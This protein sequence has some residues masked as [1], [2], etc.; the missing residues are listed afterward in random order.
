MFSVEW[1]FSLNPTSGLL[2]PEEWFKPEYSQLRWAVEELESMG[3]TLL[4]SVD[5]FSLKSEFASN[6][7]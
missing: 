2:K 4:M 7:S 1:S 3:K 5:D 6:R